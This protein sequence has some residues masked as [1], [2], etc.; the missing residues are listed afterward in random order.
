M[1]LEKRAVSDD[2][3][4][5]GFTILEL[6]IAMIVF[7]IVSGAA[8]GV[9][10]VAGRGRTTVSQGSQLNK[11][12]RLALNLVGRDTYNAGFDYP[13]KYSVKLPDN[14]M[15]TLL[16]TPADT[17]SDA[18][19]IPPIIAGNNLNLNTLSVPNTN[20]DQVTFLFKDSSFNL[21]GAVGPPDKR[22]SSSLNISSLDPSGGTNQAQ[23]LPSSG[24]NNSCAVNDIYVISGSGGSALGVVTA[25][26]DT[27][28]VQ[29]AGGDVLGFNQNGGASPIRSLNAPAAMQRVTMVTY[30]VTAD[31]IL[32]RRNYAN[33]STVT[34][35]QGWTDNP[36]VYGVTDFQIRYILD[37]GTISDNPIDTAQLSSIRQIQ[38]T[39]NA[40]T[41]E[42]NQSGQPFRVTMTT[43][44]STRNLGYDVN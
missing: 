38:F 10:L 30:F 2:S 21:V 5:K 42:L 34:A 19:A 4:Q 16:G 25:K 6:I 39:V 3:R 32:T 8:Y 44:F 27:D 14:R 23:I 37:N 11:N 36:L 29:F 33:S 35:A 22:F 13:L 20:T 31:G 1:N 26:V 15:S 28:K 7:L 18:D 9:L 43:T 12:V 41:T 24:T 40:L 17:N